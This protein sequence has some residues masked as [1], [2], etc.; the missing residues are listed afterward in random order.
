VSTDN[1]WTGKAQAQIRNALAIV[2]K[3][4]QAGRLSGLG[5]GLDHALRNA[6]HLLGSAK[7]VRFRE[8]S[9]VWLTKPFDKS[10]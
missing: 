2:E 4:R 9:H 3:L 6:L 10:T 1:D 5:A 7:A 8:N